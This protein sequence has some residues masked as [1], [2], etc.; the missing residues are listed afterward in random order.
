MNIEKLAALLDT[1]AVKIRE[2]LCSRNISP[3]SA[4]GKCIASCP[5]QG[6]SFSGGTFRVADCMACGLCVT[7]CPNHVFQLNEDK[8]VQLAAGSGGTLMIACPVMLNK[9]PAED[10]PNLIRISC[11]KQLYPELLSKLLTN[12]AEIILLQDEVVCNDCLPGVHPEI[13]LGG[14]QNAFRGKL[15]AKLRIV[16]DHR[17]L[18]GEFLAKDHEMPD[19]YDRR[20]F[21]KSIFTG[22]RSFSARL[23]DD[24]LEK[25]NL[26]T[27]E[28]HNPAA[29]PLK[30]QLL[31]D[32]LNRV[33]DPDP[34]ALLPYPELKINRCNLCGVC[35]KLCPAGA[36]KIKL[37]GEVKELV[38]LPQLC[39]HCDLCKDVCLF[40]EINWQ[41][42]LKVK[43]FLRG[44]SKTLA[45]SPPKI[46]PE[47]EQDFYF[48]ST[49]EEKLCFLCRELHNNAQ[50]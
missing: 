2:D 38:Y 5:V 40:Q 11:L 44:E 49:E 27:G 42:Y 7:A 36:L 35:A 48:Y 33:K 47:C 12:Y 3:K 50:K 22:T 9:I 13:S 14:L 16:A 32:A 19:S 24:T 1:Q 46:C 31:L 8:L 43:D 30:K 23:I 20:S 37:T 18:E 26:D 29:L 21:F 25:L 17:K 39:T 6:I 28:H 15:S 34:E 4:C 45:S 10:R 41:G